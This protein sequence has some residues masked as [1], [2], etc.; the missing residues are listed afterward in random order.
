MRMS[1]VAPLPSSKRATTPVGVASGAAREPLSLLDADAATERLVPQCAMERAAPDRDA[2]RARR[3][4][5][6]G[7]FPEPLAGT[8]PHDHARRG[9]SGGEHVG[10]CIEDGKGG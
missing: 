8:A 4:E 6:V 3:C 2:G 5:P 1:P 9:E 10:L 7:Y